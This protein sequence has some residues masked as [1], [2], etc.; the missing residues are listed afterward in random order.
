M[1]ARFFRR[2]IVCLLHCPWIVG[3]LLC[4]LS[5]QSPQVALQGKILDPAH[6]P[7]AGARITVG[8]PG[9]ADSSAVSGDTGEFSLLLEPGSYSLKIVAE[10]FVEQSLSINL[11]ATTPVPREIVL[12]IAPHIDAVTVSDSGGGIAPEHLPHVFERF[13]RVDPSRARATGGAGLG[14]A[15]VKGIVEAHGGSVEA[16]S[17]PGRGATFRFTLPLA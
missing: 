6:A 14:L 5:A 7:I 15:I 2:S 1:L 8:L 10:G 13:Y 17:E 3:V 11:G 9:H 4:P 12:E 16:R